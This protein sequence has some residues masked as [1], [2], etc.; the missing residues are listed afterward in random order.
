[1]WKTRRLP[2]WI[3]SSITLCGKNVYDD[4]IA[5]NQA[6]RD[7]ASALRSDF[8]ARLGK[9]EVAVPARPSLSATM[10]GMSRRWARSLAAMTPFRSST[11]TAP[12]RAGA[13]SES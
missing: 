10:C 4:L 12:A 3:R 13:W 6:V 8:G 2:R 7:M 9:Q 5:A 11:K 1:M